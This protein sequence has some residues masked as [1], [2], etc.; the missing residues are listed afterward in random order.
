MNSE[1]LSTGVTLAKQTPPPARE[2]VP[3]PPVEA[4]APVGVWQAVCGILA[5]GVIAGVYLHV[6]SLN[7]APPQG[8]IVAAAIPAAPA[9][10][11]RAAASVAVPA[12]T[13]TNVQVTAII[14]D[15]KG[16]FFARVNRR[17]VTVGDIVGSMTVVAISSEKVR[18][19][20]GGEERE[21][22]VGGGG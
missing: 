8:A 19:A 6:R 9:A 15:A 7:M 13:W 17:L 18:F 20:Q 4:H 21:Y 22:H 1:Y 14:G 10:K 16:R 2:P 12:G 3:G 5:A 11:P